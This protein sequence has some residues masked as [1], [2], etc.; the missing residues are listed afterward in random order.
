MAKSKRGKML[1]AEGNWRGTCPICGKKRVKLAW[2]NGSG[3]EAQKICKVCYV[4][5][6]TN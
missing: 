3:R 4:Q 5:T 1:K 6:N 2:A